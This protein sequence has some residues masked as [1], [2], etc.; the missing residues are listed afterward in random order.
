[1]I[2]LS[3]LMNI[4]SLHHNKKHTTNLNKSAND[5][6]FSHWSHEIKATTRGL[7]KGLQRTSAR[8][9]LN[10]PCAA[11]GFPKALRSRAL[12][13]IN[14]MA[15]SAEPMHLMQWCN[16]PGPSRP[17]SKQILPRRLSIHISLLRSTI[18]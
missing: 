2:L 3:R 12:F 7:Y 5:G 18:C 15:R 11:R 9:A 4:T 6:F 14:S 8:S 10:P 16:R 13:A 1:M 17:W